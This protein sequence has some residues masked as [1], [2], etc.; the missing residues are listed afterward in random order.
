MTTTG[1]IQKEVR[2]R[3]YLLDD[4]SWQADSDSDHHTAGTTRYE[5][6]MLLASYLDF[7]DEK[8]E[9]QP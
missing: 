4:G 6:L 5:A 7:L 1:G 2:I 9:G 8:K 3:V